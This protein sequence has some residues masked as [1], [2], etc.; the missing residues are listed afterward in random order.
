MKTVNPS[1]L[2]QVLA[3]NP[4]AAVI[5]VRAEFEFKASHIPGTRLH[6]LPRL[7]AG[8]LKAETGGNMKQ[9]VYLI[10]PTGKRGKLAAERVE[11]MGFT[12]VF[13][14]E[15]GLAAWKRMGYPLEEAR[16]G[17]SF[18]RLAQFIIGGGLFLAG[19]FN[20]TGDKKISLLIALIGANLF[21]NAILGR[22]FLKG[23][24]KKPESQSPL[25]RPGVR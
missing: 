3:A 12:K 11:K 10:C 2:H 19:I 5:D 14:L 7:E 16:R 24:F 18:G 23:A 9:P 13:Y 17:P 22:S 4:E 8:R 1:R 6:P 25:N 15:G 21:I 20:T